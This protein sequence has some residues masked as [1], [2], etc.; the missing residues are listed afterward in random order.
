MSDSLNAVPITDFAQTSPRHLF[1][2]GPSW[3]KGKAY[4]CSM[5]VTLSQ[6]HVPLMLIGNY[7]KVRGGS[8]LRWGYKV[9]QRW[10]ISF[11]SLWQR[12]WDKKS[13]PPAVTWE[14]CSHDNPAR[15]RWCKWAA[16]LFFSFFFIS[17]ALG[18]LNPLL[19]NSFLLVAKQSCWPQP[20]F[21]FYKL[22]T[23]FLMFHHFHWRRVWQQILLTYWC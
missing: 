6:I 22:S 9:G 10:Q 18:D 19:Q 12:M 14:H 17:T 15:S 1:S 8:S 16:C 4:L 11:S 20:S 3:V 23:C 2:L 7:H 21:D 13:S 5:D